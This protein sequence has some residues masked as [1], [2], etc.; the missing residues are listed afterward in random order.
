MRKQSVVALSRSRSCSLLNI[1]G[2]DVYPLFFSE[3]F[4]VMTAEEPYVFKNKSCPQREFALQ[5]ST[6]RQSRA[7]PDPS[8]L[9]GTNRQVLF[10]G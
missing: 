1:S 6:R 7:F 2:T 4:E 5:A 9:P 3:G 8:R 10:A